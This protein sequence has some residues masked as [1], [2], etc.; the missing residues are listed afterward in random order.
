MMMMFV[1]LFINVLLYYVPRPG[2]FGL[3]VSTSTSFRIA[4]SH[5]YVAG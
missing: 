1:C 4:W 5:M 2:D 3:H